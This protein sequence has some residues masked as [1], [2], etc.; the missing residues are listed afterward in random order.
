[1]EKVTSEKIK[2]K[3]LRAGYSACGIIPAKPFE[4]YRKSLDE[5]VKAFPESAEDYKPLY[6]LVNPPEGGKSIIVAILGQSKYKV[7]D[8]LAN[9]IGRHYLFDNR[10]KYSEDYRCNQ[11]FTAFLIMSGI[12][13]LPGGL[14][15][16]WAAA[17]AGVGKFGRNNFI[18]SVEH[19]SNLVIHTWTVDAALDY[20]TSP[21][22][23]IADECS[24]GCMVCVDSCPTNAMTDS[25]M[26]NRGRCVAQLSYHPKAPHDAATR[27]QM[28]SWLY[29]CE[30]CQKVCP[31]NNKFSGEID[32]PLLTE[33]EKYLQPESI[34][35]MDEKTYYTIVQPRFWY[36]KP[37]DIWL[38]KCNAL[39]IMVNGG[40]SK[41]HSLIKKYCDHDDPRIKEVALWGCEEL[42]L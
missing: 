32:F 14:P 25:M 37:E 2:E 40:D 27:E 7:P 8:S 38:W 12:N 19:G 4:E 39:R 36:I 26:M 10:I 29:G 23:F 34:L 24:E 1:M 18:Y 35:E 21:Q 28:G 31:M 9:H 41:Y 6:K 30:V 13:L 42:R 20:D 16:R 3:A 22:N 5:R 15:D 11:E 17:K 33:Y